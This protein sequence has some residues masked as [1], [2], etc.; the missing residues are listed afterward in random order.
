[1][2]KVKDNRRSKSSRELLDAQEILEKYDREQAF[3]KD[4]DLGWVKSSVTILAVGLTLFQLYTAF[5]GSFQSQIAASAP[6]DGCL[7]T[8]VSSLSLENREDRK[9]SSLV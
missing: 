6:F 3:R 5:F 8:C 9:R 7:G 1:M 2:D 4:N